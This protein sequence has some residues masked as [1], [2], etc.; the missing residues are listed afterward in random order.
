MVESKKEKIG[1]LLISEDLDEVL[2]VSDTIAPIYE[3]EFVEIV[4]SEKAKKDEIGTMM[5]G[6]RPKR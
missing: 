2:S 3:G 6:A 5:A 1:I 4:P